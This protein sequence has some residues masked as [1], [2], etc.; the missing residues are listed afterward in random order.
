[1]PTPVT[2]Q[3]TRIAPGDAPFD[4]SD[5]RLKTLPPIME[6]TTRAV[7][8]PQ[9]YCGKLRLRFFVEAADTQ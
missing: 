9:E 4:M 2:N 1:M 3:P 6:P 5:G 8:R 7:S